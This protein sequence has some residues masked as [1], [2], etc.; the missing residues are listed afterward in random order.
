MNLE[1]GTEIEILYKQTLLRGTVEKIEGTKG[2]PK[3]YFSEA[4][5][6]EYCPGIEPSNEDIIY[7]H[8]SSNSKRKYSINLKEIKD[9]IKITKSASH[10]IQEID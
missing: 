4:K 3:L 2:I 9:K 10:E 7:Q 1:K 6:Y 5:V 8:N